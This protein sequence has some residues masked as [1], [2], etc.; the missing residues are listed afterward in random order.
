LNLAIIIINFNTAKHLKRTLRSIL[1]SEELRK[2]DII[3]VDNGEFHNNKRISLEKLL[4]D[5]P[6]KEFRLLINQTNKGFGFACNQAVKQTNKKNIL[7]LNPDCLITSKNVKKLIAT[8]NSSKKIGVVAPRLLNGNNKDQRWSFASRS[9]VWSRLFGSYKKRKNI[10]SPHSL[11]IGAKNVEWVS[12]AC[13]MIKRKV[14]LKIN[15]FDPR[16]FLYFEDRDLCLRIKNIGYQIV[17]YQ[18][19]EAIHLESQS[20]IGWSNRKKYYYRSQNYF[21]KKH[22]GSLVANLMKILKIPYYIK[23]V[24]F[25]K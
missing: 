11:D 2:E 9:D 19:A 22:Y 5:L 23:N 4:T 20:L 1:K 16:F 25:S 24:Y 12:G 14:F 13:L 6:R 18:K 21:F 3:V 8:L 10:I 17:R 7:F 15:G